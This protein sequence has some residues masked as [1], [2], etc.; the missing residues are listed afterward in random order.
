MRKRMTV[1][2]AALALA[3]QP[4]LAQEVGNVLRITGADVPAD[5]LSIHQSPSA[6]HEL[7]VMIHDDGSDLAPAADW[8]GALHPS[9]LT[10]GQLHQDGW[11]QSIRLE[12]EGASN[13]FAFRQSG[14]INQITA[15]IVGRG[16][17]ATVIQT[18]SGNIASLSQAGTR[19]SVAIRQ[20][21]W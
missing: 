21:A 3:A 10:P 1:M 12:I 9:E 16:N 7:R 13:L 6:G 15:S 19:N 11:G 4:T 17:S 5:R 14:S 20:T 18:G 8:P 2:M